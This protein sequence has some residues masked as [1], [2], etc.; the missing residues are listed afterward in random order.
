MGVFFIDENYPAPPPLRVDQIISRFSGWFRFPLF[1]SITFS[2]LLLVSLPFP[3]FLPAGIEF[4]R[5]AG[6]C[7]G[8]LKSIQGA[9][10]YGRLKFI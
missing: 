4:S 6:Y 1:A 5:F 9:V 7:C 10:L 2:L 8:C 3:S